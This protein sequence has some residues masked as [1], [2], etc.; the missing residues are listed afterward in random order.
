MTWEIH[1]ETIVVGSSHILFDARALTEPAEELFSREVLASRGL[2]TGWAPGRGETCFLRWNNEEWA[3]RHYRRGGLV[4]YL[5]EDLY[6]GRNPK[7]TRS[8]REWRLLARLYA[9][10]LPVP[11][12]VA[13]RVVLE[14]W[15]YRADLI[16]LRIPQAHPLTHYL[17]R[18]PLPGEVWGAIGVCLRRFHTV[19]AHHADLNASNILLGE[20]D[21]ISLIDF[22][23]G[24]ICSPGRWQTG[25]LRRLRRSLLK[26]RKKLPNFHFEPKDWARLL[27][28][29]FSLGGTSR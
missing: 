27:E 12:P 20:G 5:S 2:V 17:R 24:V 25:N 28:G 9:Q 14:R 22:D 15:G 13:A 26:F 21:A 1:P 3:L 10:G 19:G 4:A 6:F 18:N 11:R 7:R 8:W 23:R 16:T 29:Y